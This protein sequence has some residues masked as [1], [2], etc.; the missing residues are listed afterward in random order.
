[1]TAPRKGARRTATETATPA[2]ETP[3][4][5]AAL[6]E[7]EQ[8]VAALESGRLDL[9]AALA[10]YERGVSLI[11]GCQRLLDAAER[12]VAV[13]TGVAADGTP[14]T[15]PFDPANPPP[16]SPRPTTATSAPAPAPTVTEP[17]EDDDLADVP[18]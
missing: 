15:A 3:G 9:D 4:F 16:E 12:R 2:T 14:Q 8:S 10:V 13:L 7:L 5:E 17:D 1:M 11:A 6:Q 18:F